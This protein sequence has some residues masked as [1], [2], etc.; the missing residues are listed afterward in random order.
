MARPTS[1]GIDRPE[2]ICFRLVGTQL[3]VLA[4]LL[5]CVA[6]AALA[7]GASGAAGVD[8][9]PSAEGGSGDGRFGCRAFFESGWARSEAAV[10]LYNGLAFLG[11]GAA[12][13][14]GGEAERRWS[15]VNGLDD[16]TR[17]LFR[18]DSSSVRRRAD[19]ASD[20]TLGISIAALPFAS[21]V[22]QHWRTGDCAE[23]FDMFTDAVESFGLA[24]LLS[25]SI[26]LASGRARPFVRECGPGAPS[27]ASCRGDDRY[28]SFVSGH[29]TLA[30][31]GAGLTCAFSVKRKAWG[32][33]FWERAAPCTVGVGLALST[34]ALRLS[35]DRHWLTDVLAGLAI[36][37]TVGW[38][39]TWGPF[40]G[41]LFETEWSE[42]GT[43]SS[44]RY[45]LPALVDGRPGL[46]VGW[47]F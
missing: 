23:S 11:V 6:P 24:I 33:G 43:I 25:E 46:R 44:Y 4:V 8:G 10:D 38:F 45:A 31:T 9:A 22:A 34:G 29:A 37:G 42:A 16:E 32:E 3:F 17:S 39:D 19:L 5:L 27:D 47:S 2:R 7:N 20:V 30:A 40:D 35:A 36:G 28:R 14:L 21:T 18:L 26:K 1:I 15:A 13:S 12:V 41:W